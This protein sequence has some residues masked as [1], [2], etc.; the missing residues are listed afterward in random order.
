MLSIQH[1]ISDLTPLLQQY[2]YLLLGLA[3][4]AEGMGIPAPG[5]SLL[6]V[7]SILSSSGQMSL[8][9]TLTV[10]GSGAFLG[11]ACGYWIGQQCEH[12]LIRRKWL[13]D[14]TLQKSH[15]FI[16]RYGIWG[17]LMSRFIEG[18]KQIMPLACG[19]AKMPFKEFL[20][21]NV[22]AVAIWLTA[23]GVAP[24]YLYEKRG[25]LL[26]FY[27]HYAVITWFVVTGAIIA[28][29]LIFIRLYQKKAM[30]ESN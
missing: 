30:K 6:V 20:V 22:L 29:I 15:N 14:K 8:S 23:F 13:S 21:G 25:S 3:I 9:L 12:I 19:I 2:G 24:A 16:E 10:A 28:S 17:L 1:L 4:A 11:N 26:A 18:F 27:H 7:A 5:Q